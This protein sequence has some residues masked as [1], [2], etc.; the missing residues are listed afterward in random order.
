LR[1]GKAESGEMC[2]LALDPSAAIRVTVA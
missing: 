2:L 1:D